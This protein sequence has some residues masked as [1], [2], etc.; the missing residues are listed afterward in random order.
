MP[1]G[2][3]AVK[4]HHGTLKQESPPRPAG[5]P[6]VPE[7][8]KSH[9]TG[10]LTG[11]IWPV[12]SG[13]D[14]RGHLRQRPVRVTVSSGYFAVEI[15]NPSMP[16]GRSAFRI[17]DGMAH[18]AGLFGEPSSIDAAYLAAVR[19]DRCVCRIPQRER[20]AG[21][22]NGGCPW[23]LFLARSPATGRKSRPRFRVRGQPRRPHRP[24]LPA[25]AITSRVSQPTHCLT[26]AGRTCVKPPTARAPNRHSWPL[27]ASRSARPG[28]ST[29]P[30]ARLVG[31]PGH[32]ARA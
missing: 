16:L 27:R 14:R 24:G 1:G 13:G 15:S 2:N 11:P 26:T 19:G 10:L 25:R 5:C 32:R 9:L 21:H 23:L 29:Q 17:R 6:A 20:D 3:R 28:I 7:G 4:S 31:G 8:M 12:S 22:G 30:E 18:R